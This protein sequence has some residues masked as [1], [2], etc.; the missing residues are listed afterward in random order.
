MFVETPAFKNVEITSKQRSPFVRNFVVVKVVLSRHIVDLISQA[1]EENTGFPFRQDHCYRLLKNISHVYNLTRD[2]S[3]EGYVML[4]AR[5]LQNI[6]HEYKAYMDWM[7]RVGIVQID[8]S[9]QNSHP[10]V[11]HPR[12][13]SIGY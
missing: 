5:Y 12:T 9:Y 6:S 11:T 1:N 8:H 3:D 2:R 10:D 7:E 4:C 13:I